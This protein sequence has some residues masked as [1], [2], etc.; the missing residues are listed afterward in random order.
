MGFWIFMLIV[1]L[2]IPAIMLGFGFHFR[3]H[4]PREINSLYGYRTRRSMLNRETWD[5]AHHVCGRLWRRV[6]FPLLPISVLAMLPVLGRD[7]DTVGL[8]GMVLCL[9]QTVV[10]IGTIFPVEAALKRT[11]DEY[12]NRRE[13]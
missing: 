2:L 4:P 1:N 9:V 13:G 12:G 11:F 3:H 10:L 7:E 5:F 8:V 6:G